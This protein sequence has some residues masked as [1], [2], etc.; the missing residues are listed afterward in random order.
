VRRREDP[1]LLTGA[2]PYVDDIPLP[3]ALYATFV[4]SRYAHA[5][6]LETNTAAARGHPDVVAVL[7]GAELARSL[8]P[9]PYPIQMPFLKTTPYHALA[10]D[11]VRYVGEPMVMVV[12]KSRAGAEDASAEVEVEYEALS[13]VLDPESALRLEAPRLYDEWGTNVR[14]EYRLAGGNLAQAFQQADLVLKERLRS[15]RYTGTPIEPRT[16]AAAYNASTGF[17][18]VYLST[19]RPHTLRTYIALT[20]GLPEAKVRVLKPAVGGAFGVKNP[21][22]PEEVLIPFLA[23]QLGRRVKWVETRHEHMLATI[24]ARD[25]IH[26]LEVAVRRDGRILGLRAR[27]IGDLGA[28]TPFSQPHSVLVTGLFLPGPYDIPNYEAEILGVVTNKVPYG[29][30]RGFGKSDSNF[31]MERL[32]DIVARRLGLDPAELRFRNFIPPERFPYTSASG[33]IYDSG[34]YARVLR[35]ALELSDY[36]RWRRVQA[37]RRAAGAF[38]GIGIGF[39]L[40]PAGAA[41][42]D[43]LTSSYEGATVRVDPSGRITVLTGMASQGQGH[44]TTLA[45]VVAD[46]LG[47]DVNDVVVV[48]GDTL[49]CPYGMGTFSSRC[50][51]AG[52]P[53]AMIAA[54]RIRAKLARIAAHLLDGDV[55]H[56]VFHNGEVRVGRRGMGFR[57]LVLLVYRSP[58]KLPPGEEPGLEATAYYAMPNINFVPDPQGR[59]NLNATYPNGA[60]V[61]VVRVDTETGRV[62]IERIVVVHDCG[63]IINPRVVEGLLH[64]GVAQGAGGALLEEIVYDDAGQLLSNSFLSYL[65]PTATDLPTMEV[66]HEKTPSP[67]IMGGFKGMAEGGAVGSTPAIINAVLDAIGPQ[68]LALV[69]TPLTPERVWRLLREAGPKP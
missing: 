9:L 44:E 45:Q 40:E 13:S 32:M 47:I 25:Q 18:T 56:V 60:F 42:P 36:Q 53:A 65:I 49:A 28:C 12:A 33:C 54:G 3:G 59:L 20:L 7:T 67:F 63:E 50:A 1:G 57:E 55:N 38:V 24:H 39:M 64:G 17:L 46:E 69:A 43:S 5:K 8:G 23:R 31:V 30:Y 52:V 62:R 35:R 19:Q 10:I 58:Y 29:A 14:L 22:Y 6:L 51:T 48:E 2:T 11:R 41:V 21:L 26:E 37:Q 4:R 15:H 16:V 61:A 68:A 27:I 66:A 34:R